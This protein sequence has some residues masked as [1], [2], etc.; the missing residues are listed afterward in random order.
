[1]TL[2]DILVPISMCFIGCVLFGVALGIVIG[3]AVKIGEF[4]IY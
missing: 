3:V 4:F 2:I 1:M